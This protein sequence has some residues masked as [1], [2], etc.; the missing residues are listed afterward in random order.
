MIA[1]HIIVDN[2]RTNS[3]CPYHKWHRIH[4]SCNI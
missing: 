4:L 1:T 3:Y 2:V